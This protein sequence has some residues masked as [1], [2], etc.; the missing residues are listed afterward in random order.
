[1]IGD[2]PYTDIYGAN[3]IGINT[4]QVYQDRREHEFP[5]KYLK[6]IEDLT[7]KLIRRIINAD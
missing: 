1:M 2:S 5:E 6:T 4:L 3:R 7:Q